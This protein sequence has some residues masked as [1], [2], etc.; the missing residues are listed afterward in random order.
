V[1]E[2]S[3]VLKLHLFDLFGLFDLQ[4]CEGSQ[5]C[6]EA[7]QF[8]LFGHNEVRKLVKKSCSRQTLFVASPCLSC[9]FVLKLLLF[10]CLASSASSAWCFGFLLRLFILCHDPACRLPVVDKLPATSCLP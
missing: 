2:V 1:K 4:L 3:S 7:S 8:H 10:T 5:L 6:V 9:H